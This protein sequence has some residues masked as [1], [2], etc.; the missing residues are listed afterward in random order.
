MSLVFIFE[1][2]QDFQTDRMDEKITIMVVKI[3]AKKV[4]RQLELSIIVVVVLFLETRPL[5]DRAPK[6][7]QEGLQSNERNSIE[8]RSAP[9][10][11]QTV[12]GLHGPIFVIISSGII[13]F[14]IIVV[15][16]QL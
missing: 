6:C 8:S 2:F 13:F 3:C 4:S 16:G 9:E 10:V 11:C 7:P 5:L 12:G 15:V 1:E 14:F